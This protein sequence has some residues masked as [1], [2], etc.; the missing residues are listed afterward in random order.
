MLTGSVLTHGKHPIPPPPSPAHFQPQKP[1]PAPPLFSVVQR[2]QIW[3]WP[4]L[5]KSRQGWCQAGGGGGGEGEAQIPAKEK[6]LGAEDGWRRGEREGLPTSHLPLSCT[7]EEPNCRLKLG[8]LGLEFNN[9]ITG[10][11]Q[12]YDKNNHDLKVRCWC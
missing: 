9:S 8:I 6:P 1:S 12:A 4:E 2:L 10:C 7:G 5:A 3:Q 11:C